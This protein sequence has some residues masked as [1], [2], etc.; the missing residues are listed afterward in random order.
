MNS[1]LAT[2]VS[3]NRAEAICSTDGG[4]VKVSIQPEER[5][6]AVTRNGTTEEEYGSLRESIYSSYADVF[7]LLQREINVMNGYHRNILREI[8]KE[9]KSYT[10]EAAV[11]RAVNCFTLP[12][13]EKYT[14]SVSYNFSR[15]VPEY[16]YLL[17]DKTGR[18]LE[19]YEALYRAED[20]FFYPVFADLENYMAKQAEE[21]IQ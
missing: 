12:G 1:I 5:K 17:Q 6:Y 11:Q 19:A 4:E 7:M 18:V 20:S 15:E 8:R 16:S 3:W 9:E 2:G 13:G 10:A 14:A 21:E